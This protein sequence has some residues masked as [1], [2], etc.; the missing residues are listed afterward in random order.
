MLMK[1]SMKGIKTMNIRVNSN[2]GIDVIRTDQELFKNR[3]IFIEGCIDYSEADIFIKKL[4]LLNIQDDK[5]V[6]DVV[7]DSPGSA[8][9]DIRPGLMMYDAL[10]T[11]P[12]P[13]RMFCI[14][15][16]YGIA[17]VLF[18][19]GGNI[20]LMLPNAFIS[21]GENR[22]NVPGTITAGNA[23]PEQPFDHTE[24]ICELLKHYTGHSSETVKQMVESNKVLNTQ[25]CLR[26]NLCD[27]T[28]G[29]DWLS[30]TYIPDEED[31]DSLPFA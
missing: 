13:I 3:K 30:R 31:D 6:I 26:E 29:I 19:C 20:R 12:A 5:K 28:A 23:A 16:A 11:S 4:L 1:L 27:F 22:V 15:R 25:E 8:D 18:E 24:T 9:G 10:M 14:G 7:I 21:F 2:N 17:G